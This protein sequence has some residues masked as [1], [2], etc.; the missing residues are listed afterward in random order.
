M[1]GKKIENLTILKEKGFSVP[2]FLVVKPG[3]EISV[4]DIPWEVCSVR[5]SANIEDSADSSFAGQFDTFLNVS[6]EDV[7]Q[8]YFSIYK[9][10]D[11]GENDGGDERM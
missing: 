1:L 2:E 3:E 10:S 6:K 4:S 7:E 5:S 8:A 9:D 11:F